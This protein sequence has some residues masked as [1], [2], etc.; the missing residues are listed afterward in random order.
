MKKTVITLSFFAFLNLNCSVNKTTSKIHYNKKLE[1]KFKLTK[2]EYTI[3]EY[4]ETS[5]DL[6]KA[7]DEYSRQIFIVIKD[8][9]LLSNTRIDIP[10]S[11]VDFRG[12]ISHAWGADLYMVTNGFIEIINYKEKKMYIYLVG[13]HKGY[14][15][16]QTILNDT[17]L[18]R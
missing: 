1:D 11:L 4:K 13:K 6:N 15:S 10:N 17:L 2:G 14:D 9:H 16:E 3:L 12:G 7:D 18:F 5:N 8:N